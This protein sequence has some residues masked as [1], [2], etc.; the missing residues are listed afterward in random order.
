MARMIDEEEME[1]LSRLRMEMGG[2]G[3]PAARRWHNLV[4]MFFARADAFG[5]APFLWHRQKGG[6][7]S[8]SYRDAAD[9]VARLA[10]GLKGAGLKPGD[11]V[12][13]VSENRPE[14]CLADLAIM[15]AGG[16]SV[17][18]YTTNGV[19]E[20]R[21]ILEDSGA[22]IAIVSGA[23]FAA[24]VT[25]AMRA[26]GACRTLV[27][28]EPGR[29]AAPEHVRVVSWEELL[30]TDADAGAVRAA[31]TMQR[32][33]LAC[34]V[35]TSGT[36][37]V[38]RGVML[39][40]GA[41]LHNISGCIDIIMFDFPA[42]RRERFLS[43]L[44]LSHAY[45][46]TAGQFLPIA[47]GAEI[48]YCP[49]LESLASSLADTKPTIMIVVPRLFEVLRR[50]MIKTIRGQGKLA[51]WLLAQNARLHR[52]S[53][54]TGK[55]PLRLRPLDALLERSL[56]RKV[57]AR[58]GGRLKAMVSGGA[59]LHP[60]VGHFFLSMGVP[61]LQGYGQTEAGPVVSCNRPSAR[62][63][64][65]TVGPPLRDT[66]ITIADDGEILVAGEC[67]MRGYWQREGETARTLADGYLHTGDIGHIDEDGHVVITDRKKDII[68]N[69][70]GENIAPQRI[71]GL[72]TVQPEIMQAMIYGDRRPWIV[73]VIVP[74]TEFAEGWAAAHGVSLR[75]IGANADFAAAIRAVVDRVNRDLV[76]TEKVRR[77]IVADQ[78]FSIESGELTP[79]LK[80]RRHVVRAR[81]GAR[82]DAL[83]GE[84]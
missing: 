24:T 40:H 4:E 51:A 83:Y 9:K 21:H 2:R 65:E 12:V 10:V 63:K 69:D 74:E 17:P 82:L 72:L 79:S 66:E 59:P 41:I 60:E 7:Q 78:P 45:E 50:R 39:H 6:W 14:F 77:I 36:S 11:R 26:G 84:S 81:Y 54:A 43:F 58:L 33:D 27:T 31:A 62:I 44:P 56:R 61:L 22:T 1:T 76:V 32:A 15:A 16:V 18:T 73:G 8:L 35:Y 20:H 25:A 71:E 46:H 64:V 53:Y 5:D 38:P 13:I 47:L 57:R 70:K 28:I 34:L 49:S 75:D 37:G 80:V 3:G 67:V 19:D 52:L 48:F 68:I 42:A 30:Q 29:I 55:V 23:K